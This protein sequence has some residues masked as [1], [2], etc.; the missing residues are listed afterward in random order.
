MA[1]NDIEIV[2]CPRPERTDRAAWD[3][4]IATQLGEA[5][6]DS[7]RRH[8]YVD[9]DACR[10]KPGMPTLCYGCLANRTTISDLRAAL[11]EALEQW[12]VWISPYASRELVAREESRIAELRAKFLEGK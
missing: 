10:A 8:E 4:D 7:Y 9:C 6:G 11:A 1:N 3:D 12:R 2:P 5:H